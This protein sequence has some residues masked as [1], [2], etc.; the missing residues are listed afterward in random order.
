MEFYFRRTQRGD[1]KLTPLYAVA[2]LRHAKELKLGEP[3]VS[4]EEFVA[5]HS[6]MERRRSE[7]QTSDSN[8]EDGRWVG[9]V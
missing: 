6:W 3:Y 1:S 4:W 8:S 7:E 2:L 5:C 9:S